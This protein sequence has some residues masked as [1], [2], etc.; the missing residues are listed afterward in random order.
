MQD[1][2]EGVV[3]HMVVGEAGQVDEVIAVLTANKLGQGL[4]ARLC[5]A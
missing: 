4:F 3:V 5:Y 2:L 1:G